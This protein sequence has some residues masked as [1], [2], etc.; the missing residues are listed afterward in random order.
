MSND[1]A[2]GFVW[3]LAAV[4]GLYGATCWAS[5]I[6]RLLKKRFGLSPPIA[7]LVEVGA[8]SK[9]P[10][11][12][13]IDSS[14]LAH[15]ARCLNSSGLPAETLQEMNQ[16]NF[17]GGPLDGITGAYPVYVQLRRYFLIPVHRR[18]N[19]FA[20]YEKSG[21]SQSFDGSQVTKH[22]DFR[23]ARFASKRETEQILSSQNSEETPGEE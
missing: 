23:F 16:A 6:C 5:L 10:E 9:R 3:G 8:I 7:Y 19:R 14:Y 13:T 1:F 4:G 2:F 20:V 11:S 17:I 18:E 22:W 15:V 12:R 21:E